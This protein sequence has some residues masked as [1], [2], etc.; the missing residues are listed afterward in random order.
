MGYHHQGPKTPSCLSPP[1][2]HQTPG[3]LSGCPSGL[4]GAWG[5]EPGTCELVGLDWAWEVTEASSHRTLD[6][7]LK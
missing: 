5:L 1:G 3:L 7:A 4:V 2:G 6:L